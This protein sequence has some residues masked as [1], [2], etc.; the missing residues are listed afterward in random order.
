MLSTK[1][2]NFFAF[3]YEKM[4]NFLMNQWAIGPMALGSPKEITW[5]WTKNLPYK[6]LLDH[7]KLLNVGILFTLVFIKHT[8]YH[9]QLMNLIVKVVLSICSWASVLAAGIWCS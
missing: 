9:K 5:I 1:L 8:V 3:L 4:Q 2:E 7:L 6:K